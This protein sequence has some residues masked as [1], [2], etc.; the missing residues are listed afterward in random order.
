VQLPA[1]LGSAHPAPGAGI[2]ARADGGA[3]AVWVVD[4]G[5][6]LTTGT[7]PARRASVFLTYDS[8]PVLSGDGWAL[9]DAAVRWL[10]G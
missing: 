1:G 5:A 9:F 8:P 7:A 2:V 10:L 6:A 3:A 4:P